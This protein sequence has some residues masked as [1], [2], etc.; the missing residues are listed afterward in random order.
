MYMSTS[1]RYMYG[2]KACTCKLI[3]L[4]CIFLCVGSLQ[5]DPAGGSPQVSRSPLTPRLCPLSSS[6]N[7]ADRISCGPTETMASPTVN[8][9][10]LV[11]E[12]SV[13]KI[14]IFYKQSDK[15]NSPQKLNWLSQIRQQKLESREERSKGSP[16]RA[17]FEKV[18]ESPRSRSS[19]SSSSQSSSQE[20]I[21]SPVP[22][23]HILYF[24]GK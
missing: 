7:V 1:W 23:V 22:K 19:Q 9:P 10:N 11:K 17:L 13:N 3:S 16:K 20:E 8:L 21:R 24:H 6:S 2:R 4:N 5:K 14:N 15:E 18:A 12:G